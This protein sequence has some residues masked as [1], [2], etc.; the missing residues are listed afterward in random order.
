MISVIRI[1]FA[2]II[3]EKELE[4]REKTV[5]R[6]HPRALAAMMN[7]ALC[8]EIQRHFRDAE[9]IFTKLLPLQVKVHGPNDGL[10]IS[11]L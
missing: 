9:Q 8:F 6:E 10:T 1:L 2:K 5:G 11:T 3:F 7:I 4:L